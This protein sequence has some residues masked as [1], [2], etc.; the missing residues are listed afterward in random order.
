MLENAAS[1]PED[2]DA[3]EDRNVRH[4]VNKPCHADAGGSVPDDTQGYTPDPGHRHTERPAGNTVAMD[5][6]ETMNATSDMTVKGTLTT[7]KACA[8]RSATPRVNQ[9]IEECGLVRCQT[10]A[11]AAGAPAQ[12]PEATILEATQ[13]SPHFGSFVTS[14]NTEEPSCALMIDLPLTCV[15]PRAHFVDGT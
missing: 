7:A 4:D 6:T 8:G 5:R 11:A 10:V 3:G 15:R 14:R 1:E 9:E 12:E 13:P 2:G